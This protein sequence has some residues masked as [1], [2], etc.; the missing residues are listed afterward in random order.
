[1]TSG[2]SDTSPSSH[3]VVGDGDPGRIEAD[4]GPGVDDGRRDPC[5]AL[6]VTS[7]DRATSRRVAPDPEAVAAARSVFDRDLDDGGLPVAEVVALLTEH[8]T[9]ATVHST[10]GR[11]FGFVTGG[12]LPAARAASVVAGE[13][14]QNVALPA[15]S[16]I[17]SILDTVAARWVRDLLGLPEGATVTFCAGASVANTTALT[18]ARDAVLARVGHDVVA[19]GLVAAPPVTVITSAEAH[20]SIDKAVGAIGLGR[21][22]VVRVPTDPTGALRADEVPEV[23]GPTIVILQAGNVNTGAMDP[24]DPLVA[25][26]RAAGAWVHIDGAFGAW[27]AASPS[28]RHLVAGMADADSWASDAHKWLNTPYDAGICA[29]RDPAD[30]RRS[31]STD[32]AYLTPEGADRAL[33][34]L[35]PQMSQRARGIEV[36]AALASLGRDGVADLVDRCCDLAARAAASLRTGGA[37]VLAPVSLNQ[38]LVA[39]GE[40]S[41]TDAVV[42]AV[43]ADGRTWAGA[44]T[45]RGRRAM[46]FSVSSWASTVADVDASVAAILDVRDQVTAD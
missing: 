22:N 41:T 34:H 1:M 13:W 6:V 5:E 19:D 35:G 4:R 11:Y 3:G 17:A 30:L 27:A 37:E 7:A 10:G 15:M 44:T 18:A 43:Q 25:E 42:A 40:D 2:W 23:G 26:L 32:A 9:P 45:W 14:D 21:D 12:T 33:M 28:R 36:W 24:M 38:V 8:G 46:R 20:A 31:F 29:V 39:F 16:P